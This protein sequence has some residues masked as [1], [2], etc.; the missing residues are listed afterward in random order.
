MEQMNFLETRTKT[1]IAIE[2]LQAFQPSEGYFLAFSGG[3][4]S[5][6]IK[7]L[8]IRSGVKFDAHYNITTVDPPELIRYIKRHHPDVIRD[9]PEM[10]MWKLIEKKKCLPMRVRRFCCEVLK[11]RGGAGR[12]VVTGI[13]AAESPARGR[14]GMVEHC[15][16]HPGKHFLHAIIDWSDADIWQYIDSRKLPYCQ[17][18]DRGHKRIGCIMCPMSGNTERERDEYPKI[19]ELYFRAMKT[20]FKPGG[21]RGDGKGFDTP[22]QLFEFW[23]TGGSRQKDTPGQMMIFD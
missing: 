5:I 8:A 15:F 11:E 4:D 16:K 22:E 18:Y 7:D 10:N 3:K 23:L 1:E 2:R 20:W 9:R 19:A 13:R 14:R 21:T 17:L 6:V 12:F